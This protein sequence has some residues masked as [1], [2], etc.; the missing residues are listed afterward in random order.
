MFLEEFIEFLTSVFQCILK[1]T[2]FVLNTISKVLA[3]TCFL[4][5]LLW[6]PFYVTLCKE[7][8]ESDGKNIFSI[9]HAI[10]VRN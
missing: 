8:L 9:W 1:V 10:Q 6:P 4:P 7:V 3:V 5:V 2:R